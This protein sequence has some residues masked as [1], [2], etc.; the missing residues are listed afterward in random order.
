MTDST[1]AIGPIAPT[2]KEIDTV[3]ETWLTE[4]HTRFP[5]L[6]AEDT[7]LDAAEYAPPGG[8]FLAAR[9]MGR[10]IGCGGIRAIDHRTCEIKRLCVIPTERHRGVG[11]ALLA[12]LEHA[13]RSL[14]H[15]TLRLDTDGSDPRAKELFERAGYRPIHDYSGTPFAVAWFERDL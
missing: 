4:L 15:D 9:S 10:V 6:T 7:A 11:Q 2:A 3:F 13:A 8:A 1:F 12:A 14:G 5:N